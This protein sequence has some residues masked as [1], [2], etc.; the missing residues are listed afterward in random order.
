MH[1]LLAPLNTQQRLAAQT[2]AGPVLILAGA[3]S[4]KTK[5]L[6]HRIAYLLAT[7]QAKPEEI[8]AVT[9]TN[10]AAKEMKTRL[11]KLLNNAVA[12][13]VVGTFHSLCAQLLRADIAL[14]GYRPRFVI[15]DDNDTTSLIKGI[16]KDLGYDPKAISYQ[17][18]K[19]LISKAKN[20]LLSPSTY[21]ADAKANIEQTVS[22]IYQRYQQTLQQ[23]NAL[24]FDD[25]IRLT[26]QILQQFPDRLKYY[27]TKFKYLLV[28]E[29]QDTNHAQFTLIQLLAEKHQNICVVG[30]DYQSIYGWRQADIQNILDFEKDYPNTKVILL[31]QNYRSTQHILDGA[32]AIIKKNSR[33]KHKTL[34]TENIRGHKITV[35]E[36]ANEEAEGG[37]I[38]QEIF[39]IKDRN[40]DST[41][42]IQDD[43][44]IQYIS[45]EVP[46]SILDRIMKSDTFKTYR[47]HT[48]LEQTIKQQL[49]GMDLS[50]YVILYRTNAQSRALEETFLKYNVPYRIVGGLKFYERKEIK[51]L[52]AYARALINPTDW[53]S[54]E[55]ICNVPTRSLGKT[56]WLKI[57]QYC[58]EQKINYLSVNEIPLRPAAQQAF[59][60]FQASMQALTKLLPKSTPS[61]LMHHIATKTGYAQQFDEHSEEGRYRL[62]NI[63]ELKSVTKKY[64]HLTGADGISAFLE[65][66]SLLS[67]QDDVDERANA[68]QMMTVHAAKGL[69][70]N[71]VFITGMEEGLFPHSRSL[72]EPNEMEEERRLC[73]VALT[74]AKERAYFIYAT[75]RT[76]YGETKITAPARFLKD[77][78]KHVVTH[79]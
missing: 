8:L 49:P 41:D 29:Y 47:E 36:A 71:T 73:Y 7:K 37:F 46:V 65:Q 5:T 53:V 4:G 15:Y 34:W 23:N 26:V 55:R 67:D 66:V 28:D 32:N 42:K 69:E 74:R 3:G 24:D 9:F 33:Q 30:D 45:E 76:V 17:A 44:D 21:D 60:A 70:F 25:L 6:I 27:Q 35:K 13:P 56:S 18:V 78:P 14:L 77:L 68:V 22:K 59:L 52:I 11:A 62:E 10:K 72:F 54:L 43:T 19:A 63:A 20:K 58:R 64:D 38:I 61:E 51:D 40:T 2:I 79:E 16:I 31:E 48:A 75:Q 39:N 50:K 57:E 1:Q 12:M